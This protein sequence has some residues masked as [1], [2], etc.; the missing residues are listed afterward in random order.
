[1][2]DCTVYNSPLSAQQQMQDNVKKMYDYF[3]QI[4]DIN[5]IQ[6]KDL[7]NTY[8]NYQDYMDLDSSDDV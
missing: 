5:K 7:I 2:D 1:M 8:F 6:I 3:I 4:P